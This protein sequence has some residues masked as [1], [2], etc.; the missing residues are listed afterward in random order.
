M[1]IA[2]WNVNSLRVRLP[3][4]LQWMADAD[5]DVVCLQETKVVDTKFPVSELN[6]AGYPHLAFTG[7]KTYN[8]VAIISKHPLD[9]VQLGFVLGEP[10]PQSPALPKG[11]SITESWTT[12]ACTATSSAPLARRTMPWLFS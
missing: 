10:D 11:S 12:I 1:K 2:T 8:G 3:H 6:E 7:Q 4:L 5:P 9:E